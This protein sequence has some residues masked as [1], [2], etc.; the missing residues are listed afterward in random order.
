MTGVSQQTLVWNYIMGKG[1]MVTTND[2]RSF[3][4]SCPMA[5]PEKR[6]R[7][8]YKSGKLNRRWITE[9]EKITKN[10]IKDVMIY[11]IPLWKNH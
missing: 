6:A 10:L 5:D 8:L 11:F 1:G 3:G 2:L 7:E 4:Y 9:E